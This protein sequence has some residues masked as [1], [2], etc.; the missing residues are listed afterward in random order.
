MNPEENQSNNGAQN[1]GDGEHKDPVLDFTKGN[2]TTVMGVL[3][4]IGPLVI[5]P[6]LMEKKD[7]FVKFHTKQGI[8]LF[9]LELVIMVLG[10][11][12]YLFMLGTLFNL[13]TL[14]LSIIGI[15]NVVQGQKKEL[16]VIGSLANSIKI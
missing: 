16:P 1:Q 15:V 11:M 6:F 13:A 8:V 2:N 5:I 10:S 14:V 7:E 3:A 4:Y 9:G 12:M